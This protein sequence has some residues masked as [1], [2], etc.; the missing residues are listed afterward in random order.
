MVSVVPPKNP[1]ELL[2]KALKLTGKIMLGKDLER[3][4]EPIYSRM[5][6]SLIN[7]GRGKGLDDSFLGFLNLEKF[8]AESLIKGHPV[9]EGLSIMCNSGFAPSAFVIIS[10]GIDDPEL[11]VVMERYRRKGCNLLFLSKKVL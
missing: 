2:K 6:K 3:V 5:L 1:R 7:F 9:T 11:S 4:L 8:V 10:S